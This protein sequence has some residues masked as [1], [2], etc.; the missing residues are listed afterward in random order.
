MCFV[1]NSTVLATLF[2]P[3]QHANKIYL[4]QKLN[5]TA[6][7]HRELPTK[8][9][10]FLSRP[11]NKQADCMRNCADSCRSF[12]PKPVDTLMRTSFSLFLFESTR[13]Q[14]IIDFYDGFPL[15]EYCR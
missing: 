3:P 6:L 1:S 11:Q 10:D 5:V 8:A 14:G 13:Q 2:K 12:I 9:C 15:K 4:Y 7:Y